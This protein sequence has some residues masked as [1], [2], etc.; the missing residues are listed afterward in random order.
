MTAQSADKDRQIVGN[1][2]EVVEIPALAGT[3][4]YGQMVALHKTDGY[5][6]NVSASVSGHVMGVSLESKVVTTTSGSLLKVARGCVAGPFTIAGGGDYSL[7]SNKDC[8][9]VVFA[10]D[11]NTIAR[12]NKAKTYPQAGR[13]AYMDGPSGGAMVYFDG[14]LIPSGT[15]SSGS[16]AAG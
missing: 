9:N 12:D 11:N 3:Y 6:G 16:V 10:A 1:K 2:Y 13:L 5:L 7:P 8:G 15:L 4:Y 14:L